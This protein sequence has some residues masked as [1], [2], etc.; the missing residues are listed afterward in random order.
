[1]IFAKLKSEKLR[2]VTIFRIAPVLIVSFVFLTL[3]ANAQTVSSNAQ[4]NEAVKT[5]P[6]EPT[7]KV[8]TPVLMPVWK[9]YKLVTI[10]MTAGEVKE[11]LGKAEVA[12]KDGFY[13]EISDVETVQI[14]L[15]ADQK[16]RAII[17]MYKLTGGTAPKFEDVM[18][19]DVAVEPSENGAVYKLVRYP[20]A[21]YWVAYNRTAGDNAMVTV[22]IQ[23]F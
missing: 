15:D 8:K 1:M 13:Y 9:N 7:E 23:K 19:M 14:A 20:E 21:G 10:G 16:V 22:T 17:V 5:A 6:A 12:D 4:S 3:A 11:K 18:G 2:F